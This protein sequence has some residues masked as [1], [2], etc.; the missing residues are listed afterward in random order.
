VDFRRS[1]GFAG[2]S[3]TASTSTDDLVG[4]HAAQVRDL[5][6]AAP[7]AEPR[8]GASSAS[9]GAGPDRFQYRLS[10]SDGQ[11]QREYTWNE[12]QVPDEIRP[13]IGELTRRAHPA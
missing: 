12:T 1:G 5:L 6:A 9:G 4:E 11:R 3:L 7:E 8:R 13:L 2:I 10:L